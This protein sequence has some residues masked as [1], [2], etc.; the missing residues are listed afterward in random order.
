MAA[1]NKAGLA[2]A[3]KNYAILPVTFFESRCA[4]W[5]WLFLFL[6]LLQLFVVNN[7]W[8]IASSWKDKYVR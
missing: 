1:A 5:K 4:T 8:F 7:L 2:N 6:T 3:G